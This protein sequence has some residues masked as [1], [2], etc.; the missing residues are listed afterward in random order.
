MLPTSN[1]PVQYLGRGAATAGRRCSRRPTSTCSTSSSSGLRAIQ[2]N[3]TVL[4]LFNQQTATSKFITQLRS[5]NGLTFDQA[6]FYAGDINF[7]SLIQAASAWGRAGRADVP[8]STVPAGQRLSDANRGAVRREVHLLE[9]RSSLTNSPR[10]LLR[11]GGAFSIV[12]VPV[13]VVLTIVGT[14]AAAWGQQAN[15]ADRRVAE[16]HYTRRLAGPADR[17]VRRVRQGVPGG[18]RFV[19]RVHPRVLRAGARRD[20]AEEI[21]GG[22]PRL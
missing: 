19:S 2:L 17:V 4:N 15:V 11:I 1:Y 10:R 7:Q 9:P 22:R 18:D 3:A 5:G 16:Q 6:A 21:R 12:E 8:G 13:I 14:L 20:G